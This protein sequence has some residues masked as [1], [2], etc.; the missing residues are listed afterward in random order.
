MIMA[1]MTH[2][3]GAHRNKTTLRCMIV[4]LARAWSCQKVSG[5]QRGDGRILLRRE[6]GHG[7]L[8]MTAMRFSKPAAIGMFSTMA[9]CEAARPP[10][11]R[12]IPMTH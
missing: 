9:D 11:A 1:P 8:A 10:A 5:F 6:L 3:L 2:V 4:S 12:E 7:T